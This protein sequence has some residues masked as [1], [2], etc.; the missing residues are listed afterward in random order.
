MW[1]K[2]ETLS[3]DPGAVASLGLVEE[4]RRG[5]GRGATE[6]GPKQVIF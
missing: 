1:P 4:H 5:W 6:T 3:P 2:T